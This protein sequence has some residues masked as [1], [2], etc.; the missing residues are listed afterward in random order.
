MG[1]FLLGGL[2]VKNPRAR[3]PALTTNLSV[4]IVSVY[5][6]TKVDTISLDDAPCMLGHSRLDMQY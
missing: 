2:Y 3:E 6:T 4:C 5:R 1:I